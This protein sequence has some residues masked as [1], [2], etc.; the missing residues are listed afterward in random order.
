MVRGFPDLY[1]EDQSYRRILVTEGSGGSGSSL[2]SDDLDSIGELYSEDDF[3]RRLW[4]SRRRQL[5]S[6]ASTSLKIMASAVLFETS[7]SARCDDAPWR[8]AFD[9]VRRAQMFPVF[10]REVEEGEQRGAILDQA[11][12]RLV[13]FD[14]PGLTK[15]SNAASRILRSRPS[16]SPAARAWQ[17]IAGSSATCSARWRSCAPSSAGRGSAATPPRSPARSRARRR[18]PRARGRSRARA[19]SGRA[20]TPSRI[21][22]SRTP[23]IRPTSSFLPSG[24]APMMTSRHCAASSSLACTWTPRK[25][26]H[27]ALR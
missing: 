9:D 14:A 21:A 5:L 1:Y 8:R 4:P 16:R 27:V 11:L 20:A 26:I 2:R 18:R 23:S 22:H 25:E 6:A 12:D 17:L 13:V 3:R 7:W 24:V 15:A 10:S 19:A